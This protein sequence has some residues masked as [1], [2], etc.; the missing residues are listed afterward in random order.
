[1]VSK[2]RGFSLIE[3]TIVLA[4]SV[5]MIGAVAGIF[6]LRRSTVNDDAAKQIA[7]TIQTVQNEAKQGLGPTTESGKSQLSSVQGSLFGEAIEFSN[8][9]S[10]KPCTRVFKLMLT[11]DG[12]NVIPYENYIVDSPQLFSYN[13]YVTDTPKPPALPSLGNCTSASFMSCYTDPATSVARNIFYPPISMD[14]GKP[15][16]M[17]VI[18]NR[19]GE[20]Y[21]FSKSALTTVMGEAISVDAYTPNR[22]GDLRL[23]VGQIDGDVASQSSWDNSQNKYYLDI[24]L[25]GK[26]SIKVTKQ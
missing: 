16:L 11:S 21:V 12:Q 1:M 8:N 2:R 17:I 10:G 5:I 7:S 6:S 9:C 22:Q 23:G 3:V 25:S 14:A 20:M 13:L 19:T 18:K 4:L 26:N 15:S 24:N